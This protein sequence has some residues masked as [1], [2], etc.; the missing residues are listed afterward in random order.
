MAAR[1]QALEQGAQHG[2]F[3][4]VL[5]RLQRLETCG[6]SS[7]ASTQEP[8]GNDRHRYTLIFGGWQK[9]TSR[10]SIVQ[11]VHDG[12]KELQVASLTGPRKRMSLMTFRVRQYEDYQGMRDRMAQV[13][14]AVNRKQVVVSGGGRM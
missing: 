8:M 3:Q 5:D 11:Q 12:L 7:V 13:V 14:G 1:L 10:K 4:E 9:D 2:V 6:A